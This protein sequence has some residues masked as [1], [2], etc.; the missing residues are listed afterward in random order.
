SLH[1]FLY[2][3]AISFESFIFSLTTLFSFASSRVVTLIHFFFDISITGHTAFAV[4]SLSRSVCSL[5]S[6]QSYNLFDSAGFCMLFPSHI[7]ILFQYLLAHLVLISLV[8]FL[9][10][11]FLFKL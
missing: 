10:C 7:S 2:L 6:L 8:A 11:A 5:C 3:S 1:N 9:L 4:P